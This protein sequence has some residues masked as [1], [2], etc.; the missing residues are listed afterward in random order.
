MRTADPVRTE[1]ALQQPVAVWLV[2][3]LVYLLLAGTFLGVL[4]LVSISS[5]HAMRT[6]SPARIQAHGDAQICPGPA[7]IVIFEQPI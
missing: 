4:N 3:G 7:A 6:L 2:T 1:I 5:R